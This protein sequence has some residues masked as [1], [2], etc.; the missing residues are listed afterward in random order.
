MDGIDYWAGTEAS[1]ERYASA[2][3]SAAAQALSS[4]P[5]DGAEPGL[6]EAHGNVGVVRIKGALTNREVRWSGLTSYGSIRNA[7]VE[8]ALREDMDGILLDIDSGGG[9]VNGLSDLGQLI[10]MVGTV[11]PVVAYSGGDMASAAYWIGASASEIYAS[12]TATVGSIGVVAVHMDQSKLLSDMGI[13]P[14][15]FRAGE[16]KALASPYE[17]LSDAAR[18]QV[19]RKI[20]A[21]EAVFVAHV[22]KARG[23]APAYVRGRLAEGREF[24]GAQALDAGLVDGITAIDALVSRMQSRIDE[25][26]SRGAN[27]RM[28]GYMAKKLLTEQAVA[29][30]AEGAGLDQ[31]LRLTKE[32]Q[33]G[34]EAAVEPPKEEAAQEAAAV[35]AQAETPAQA[36]SDVVAFLRA[37]LAE[38]RKELVQA[39]AGAL[40][41][42]RNLEAVQASLKPLMDI[43]AQRINSMR[44][45]MGHATSDLAHL[46]AESLVE[47]FTSTQAAFHGMFPVGGVAQ[48]RSTEQAESKPA[49]PTDPARLKAASISP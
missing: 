35:E 10:Q 27:N 37:D 34:E 49:E 28:E 21:L 33:A 7:V 38:A 17:K 39:Q 18:E 45:G 46:G 48:S 2:M 3:R 1:H 15:V 23:R 44:I 32:A 20:D 8:A 12:D 31:A 6:F 29:A 4:A 30:L 26:K 25:R 22:A 24:V 16:F 41:A 43:A 36:N 5:D 13:T 40:V 14:T 11:K 42:E 9:S 47:M 19:Q